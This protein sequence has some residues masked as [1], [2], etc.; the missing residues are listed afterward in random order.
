MPPVATKQR[1]T[2]VLDIR[3]GDQVLV[4]AGKD[5]GKRGVVQRV[6]TNPQGW[7]KS[8]ARYGAG[9]QRTSPLAGA[10]VVIEGV[11]IAKRHTKPR[12]SAGRTDRQPRIQQGGILDIAMPID[13]SNVMVIC[14]SCSRPTR[15]RHIEAADGRSVRACAHCGEA[16]T[17]R[18]KKRS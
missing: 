13:I 7:K 12:S 14:P 6:V 8:T 15:I 1:R 2:R 18:E 4:L 11:N 10:S 5:A 17:T 3:Q 16:L 9:W